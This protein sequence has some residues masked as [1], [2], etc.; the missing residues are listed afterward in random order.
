MLNSV[1]FNI[2]LDTFNEPVLMRTGE[3]PVEADFEE[4]DDA[5]VFAAGEAGTDAKM[6]PTSSIFK[7]DETTATFYMV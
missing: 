2:N 7:K 3:S 5:T 4:A 1:L 6:E